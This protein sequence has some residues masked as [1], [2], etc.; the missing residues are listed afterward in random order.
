MSEE[1]GAQT[2]GQ[3]CAKRTTGNATRGEERRNGATGK[4]KWFAVMTPPGREADADRWLRRAAFA[5]FYPHCRRHLVVGPRHQRRRQ[6]IVSAYFPRYLFVRVPPTRAVGEVAGV[7][8]VTELV[9]IG[10]APVA[11]PGDVIRAIMEHCDAAGLVGPVDRAGT[12]DKWNGVFDGARVGDLAHFGADTPFG[13]LVAT[14]ASLDGL[15]KSGAVKIWLEAFRS[16]RP[17]DVPAGMIGKI[18]RVATRGEEGR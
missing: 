14:I 9:G 16:T 3:E 15:D 4:A 13:G 2:R 8:Y 10:G 18:E 12:V 7:L 6:T 11:I 5:T 17:V 1:T